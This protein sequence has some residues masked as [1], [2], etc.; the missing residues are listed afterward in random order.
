MPTQPSNE[1]IQNLIR[2]QDFIESHVWH[3]AKS[4]PEIPHWYC[5]LK[6]KGDVD[7]FRWFANHI[8]EYSKPGEFYGK[9]YYYYYKDGFKYWMM[10]EFPD[11]CD[12][13]NRDVVEGATPITFPHYSM[14]VTGSLERVLDIFRQNNAPIQRSDFHGDKGYV[15]LTRAGSDNEKTLLKEL[16]E[17]S[18][19]TAV[20]SMYSWDI[21]GYIPFCKDSI[22]PVE[23]GFDL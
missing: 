14:I 7:E 11:Q 15:F 9:T 10:D 3:F 22:V 16:E 23:I 4:M 1:Y 13:I 8:R 2:V 6:D 19:V 21:K 20:I 5:L 18:D 17:S 12:L